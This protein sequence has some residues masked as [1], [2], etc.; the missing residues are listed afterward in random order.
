MG[1]ITSTTRTIPT[2]CGWCAA[3]SDSASFDFS[4]LYHA[5]LACRRGKRN[6]RN[7]LIYESRLLDNLL[8]TQALLQ[9][10]NWQPA[11]SVCFISAGA[12]PREIH[13]ANF[14]DRVVHH[15]LMP[16][17][18]VLYEPVFIHDSYA[19]RK[20]KG[21]HRAVQR[22][23]QFMRQASLNQQ[24]QAWYL[25]LDIANFFNRI[26]RGKLYRLLQARLAKSVADTK[27]SR[28]Q[29]LRLRD[30]CK[31]I[32]S[33]ET[34]AHAIRQGN[35]QRFSRLPAHK[36][37]LNAPPG[38][39]LPIGDLSSQFFANVYLDQL[40]QFIK[41][42]LHC[43]FYLRYVDD[44]ILV[45]SDREQ[46]LQWYQEIEQFLQQTLGLQLR[47]QWYLRRVSEGADFLGYI[48]RPHYR[49]SRRRVVANLHD[50]LHYYQ[51]QLISRQNQ[52]ESLY[53]PVSASSKL[54]NILNSY[55][56]H[57]KHANT[58]NLQR[59]FWQRY[60][61]LG[62]IIQLQGFA[63][64]K[65]VWEAVNV[66]SLRGQ[67]RY[68][69]KLYPGFIIIVQTGNKAEI[70]DE[71]VDILVGHGFLRPTTTRLKFT[72]T[73]SLPLAGLKSLRRRLRSLKLAH[74]FI[75]EQGYHKKGLKRRVLRLYWRPI[76]KTSSVPLV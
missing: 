23:Q 49:L 41:H 48:I 20:N 39:G 6:T 38:K 52:G 31:I 74:C 51:A 40:D 35:P 16:K 46:L 17:L 24:R 55:F 8:Q 9:C 62:N 13:A 34:A 71:D 2:G 33:T 65:P 27:I 42:T 66:N 3:D 69:N 32:L 64:L 45:H 43:R 22:L 18:E 70:Y 67:W 44:F 10:G 53:L 58:W 50:R 76:D 59:A 21:S 63:R 73:L 36:H 75:A 57:F 7:A 37:L 5:W 1:T 47:T 26:D 60:P 19:N 68:F 61:W 72:Q 25:Q 29:G 4:D 28:E 54:L 30:L 12:K 14:A 11:R 15:L 56:A